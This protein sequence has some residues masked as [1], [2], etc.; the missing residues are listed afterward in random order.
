MT[1]RYPIV[2]HDS[3]DEDNTLHRAKQLDDEPT[4][5]SAYYMGAVNDPKIAE[6]Y[7][8]ASKRQ[9]PPPKDGY[10]FAKRDNR[11][12]PLKPRP[13]PCKYCGSINYWDKECPWYN[14]WEAKYGKEHSAQY[15]EADN[16]FKI[17][18]T[19]AF[20]SLNA[21][22]SLSLYLEPELKC[23]T[24]LSH[25]SLVELGLAY[26]ES[27]KSSNTAFIQEIAD[28]KACMLSPYIN[29]YII[30]SIYDLLTLHSHQIKSEKEL[31]ANVLATMQ[32]KETPGNFLPPITVMRQIC[33]AHSME[34]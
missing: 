14:L 5:N 13:S 21:Y 2:G 23:F 27:L 7:A 17:M 16:S 10:P 24:Y 22:T 20:D 25:Y 29:E 6:V 8:V 33:L 3:E 26:K 1:E 9:R 4:K 32:L 34:A 19:T 18:Y 28:D 11:K 12:S 31:E 15:V 30:E